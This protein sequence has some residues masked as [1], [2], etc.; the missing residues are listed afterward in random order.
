MPQVPFLSFEDMHSKIR[1]EVMQAIEAVYDG[2]W[3]INGK[4]VTEFEKE[5]AAYNGVAHCS[6]VANGLDAIYLALKVLG[7]KEGD[8]VI[9][10]S[11]T[12][13]AT[14]LA[15]TW[16]GGT[17]VMVEP[18][19]RTYNIHPANIEKAITSRTKAIIPVHLYGQICEMTRIMDIAKKHNLYVIED[20]AQ[21]HGATCNGKMAGSFGH[22]N[23]TSFYPGKNLGAI[24]DAGAV[25]S[26][27]TE[28]ITKIH[29]LRNYGSEKKYYNE[30]QGYNM[31]L[32]ELQAAVLRVKLKHLDAWTEDRKKI[33]AIYNNLLQEIGDL[34]LPVTA[35]GCTHSYHLYVIR[36]KH[37]NELQ[38]FMNENGVGTLIHYPIPI[39]MQQAYKD[40]G[41]SKGQF[42]LA[43]AMSEEVLSLPLFPGM[44]E[45]QQ[46]YVADI[47]RKY[48]NQN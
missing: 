7:I 40:M 10:P 42:P 21:A 3:Y 17:P 8:E 37:R 12:Y 46:Q 31:R 38:K 5:Y 2:Y 34:Q 48:F 47:I 27:D 35:E 36:T 41:W 11:N 33:A 26:D 30:V 1:T 13:I 18:D 19:E 4:N 23:A 9:I 14:A 22:L 20:N 6:G 43:E 24:G 32:D 15:V 25:T 45:E 28:L 16:C 39:H 29:H 44:K